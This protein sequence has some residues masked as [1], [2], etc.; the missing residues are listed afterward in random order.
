[1][2][3]I[4]IIAATVGALT[5]IALNLLLYRFGNVAFLVTALALCLVG[6]TFLALGGAQ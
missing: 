4:I 3:T 1:M 6:V 2:S 5:S